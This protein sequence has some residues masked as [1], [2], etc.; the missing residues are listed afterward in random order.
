MSNEA[1]I[2]GN[3]VFD[4]A[5]GKDKEIKSILLD[6]NYQE[7]AFFS[8]FRNG[9][10]GYSC[11]CQKKLIWSKYINQRLLNYTQR[12]VSD[13]NYLFF[14]QAIL[15]LKRLQEQK[16]I[17]MRKHS[18]PL[19]ASMFQNYKESI[20]NILRSDQAFYFMNSIKGSP[21]YWKNFN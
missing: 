11:K 2:M 7:L 15:Q 19:N 4:I 13:V 18:S 3:P 17:A 10:F 21:A 8:L 12:F 16:S 5:P 14:C 20:R 1:L 6:E 9:K